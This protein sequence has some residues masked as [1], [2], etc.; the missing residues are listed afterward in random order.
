[1]A[2]HMAGPV[3][4]V[5]GQAGPCFSKFNMEGYRSGHNGAVLKTVRAV[6][7]T[8]VRIPYPPPRQ[9]NTIRSSAA[10]GGV[11][12]TDGVVFPF[13]TGAAML[14]PVWFFQVKQN[15]LCSDF[16]QKSER[17]HFAAPS[18]QIEPAPLG[19]D[20]AF[21]SPCKVRFAPT[22]LEEKSHPSIS[23]LPIFRKRPRLLR[24]CFVN[25]GTT[26][27]LCYQAF[28]GMRGSY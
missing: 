25:A 5:F 9:N 13:Q 27:S 10:A 24:R 6:M 15:P 23:L 11:R 16:F 7:S 8:G 2:W 18:F 17:T 12:L 3:Y 20:L 26:L 1:M 28:T 4:P 19:L 21:P 22:F 14:A